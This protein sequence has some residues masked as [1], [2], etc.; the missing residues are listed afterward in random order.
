[1]D[2]P[3]A[4][5][6]TGAI[7]RLRADAAEVAASAVAAVS[8][9][10][11]VPAAIPELRA[12]LGAAPRRLDVLA[13]GKAAAAMFEAFAAVAP[14]PI[15]RCLVIG[16]R[17]PEGWP[18]AYP[19]VAGGHPLANAASVEG[20]RGALALAADVPQDGCLVC[21][22][23]G[24]ASALMAAPMRGLTLGV[25]QR[26]VA[27]VMK[28]GG[29][30]TALNAVRKH[31]SAVKG[32]RLAAACAG[33]TVT[34][35]ISDVIGDDLSVI[36]SGPGVPD[37]STWADAL[38]VLRRF[39]G[40]APAEAAVVAMA[41]AGCA[42]RIADTPKAGDPRLARAG[43]R[44]IGGRAQA[45]A[46]AADHVARLGYAPVVLAAPVAGEAR[47]SALAWWQDARARVDATE[48]RVAVISSGE[49]TVT[50]R[51]QGRGG[52]NQEFA[53]ALVE[54]LSAWPWPA[55][56]ISI[57]TDGID[58]PTDAAGAIVDASTAQR[59]RAL[60]LD[61]P[62]AYLERNDS[63]AFFAALGDLV[64]PGPSDTN[65]GDIQVLLTTRD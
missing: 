32:G 4:H 27:Q 20:G 16:P 40:D 19:F 8:P 60:A 26:V 31:L 14:A 11:L 10:V 58:G 54:P 56:L 3:P 50:V 43:A 59:A 48:G 64:R 21:L 18:A 5:Q 1:M 52:R 13:V 2:R 51:G 62:H 17:L 39:T 57:G 47:T 28:A 23:S 63:Y 30:I 55:A 29:D 49:T 41:E 36:G 33:A 34:L 22:L 65:V 9:H 15:A 24:G 45:M 12:A 6:L 46:A 37:G 53:L 61:R 35:A 25:K 7:E 44:V 42:G 38:D